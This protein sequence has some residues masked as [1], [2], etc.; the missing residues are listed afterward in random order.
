MLADVAVADGAQ[1]RIGERVQGDVGVRVAFQRVR[2]GDFQAAQPDVVAGNEA[3][4]VEALARAHIA[5][6][7]ECLRSHGEVLRGGE[8]LASLPSTS[9]TGAGHSAAAASSVRSKRPA[10]HAASCATDVGKRNAWGVYA[11][12]GLER[13]TLRRCAGRASAWGVGDR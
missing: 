4:H 8:R 11:R 12:H 9:V 3:V 13:S 7:G 6:V 5:D 1:Q 10:A 2:V